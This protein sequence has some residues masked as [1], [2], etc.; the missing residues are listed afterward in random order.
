GVSEQRENPRRETPTGAPTPTS[1]DSAG[2]TSQGPS[3]RSLLR[4]TFLDPVLIALV[5]VSMVLAVWGV[6]RAATDAEDDSTFT[7]LLMMGASLRP[8]AWSRLRPLWREDASLAIMVSLV[9]TMIVPIVVAW[10]PAIAAAVA[11]SRPSVVH[12][13]EST[14][15][16]NGW[17]YFF[18]ADDGSL[19]G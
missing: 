8:M 19:I 5:L 14:R 7:S 11:V 13:I 2:K 1:G 16:E 15:R 10:P 3:G 6:S 18:G 17:L 9:R 4:G 12:S